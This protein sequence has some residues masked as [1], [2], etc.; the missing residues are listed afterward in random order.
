[1]RTADFT[2]NLKRRWQF[3]KHFFQETTK[4]DFWLDINKYAKSM[5]KEFFEISLEEETVQYMQTEKNQKIAVF[6]LS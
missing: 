6:M 3:A 5:T 2:G 1:M 4:A